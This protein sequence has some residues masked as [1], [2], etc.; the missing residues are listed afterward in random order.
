MAKNKKQSNTIQSIPRKRGKRAKN[1]SSQASLLDVP[2]RTPTMLYPGRDASAPGVAHVRTV[3]TLVVGQQGLA[4][5]YLDFNTW[6]S[7]ARA[8]LGPYRYFR[9]RDLSVQVL[10]TGGAA[11]LTSTAFNV[12][13]DSYADAGA[14]AIL[15]DDYC[16]LA[17]AITRPILRPPSRYWAMGTRT[18]YSAIDPTAGLPGVEERVNGSLNFDTASG[19]LAPGTA[20]GYISVEAS[21]EFHT[22][23]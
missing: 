4:L 6:F 17:N 12:V 14:N 7:Y 8:I 3:V 19:V 15:N 11:S 20:V 13:N 10:P 9:L 16:A 22:L 2:M 1:A 21:F 23:V 18:W 5:S